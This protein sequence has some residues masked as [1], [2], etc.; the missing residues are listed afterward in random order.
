MPT[1]DDGTPAGYPQRDNDLKSSNFLELEKY[2]RITFKS[3]RIEPAG[4]YW[5]A[6]RF[7]PSIFGWLSR[8]FRELPTPF[9]CAIAP[10]TR[11]R[12]YAPGSMRVI[13]TAV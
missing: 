8:P 2:P 7:T 9:L 6:K 3:T 5:P 10:S 11:P 1:A 4:T 12:L 13:R